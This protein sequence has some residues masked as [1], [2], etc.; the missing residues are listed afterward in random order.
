[1]RKNHFPLQLLGSWNWCGKRCCELLV[2]NEPLAA[3]LIT[4]NHRGWLGS[5]TLGP[6]PAQQAPLLG[7]AGHKSGACCLF[8]RL[9][10]QENQEGPAELCWHGELQGILPRAAPEEESHPHPFLGG[11]LPGFL[12]LVWIS[13]LVP[14]VCVGIWA[15]LWWRAVIPR[16]SFI[17]SGCSMKI[18][19]PEAPQP[20]CIVPAPK[21]L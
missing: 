18:L 19:S 21:F 12:A 1:M 4:A 14:S 2:M 3:P 6:I 20:L 9:T 5:A 11:F 7:S 13:L 10:T 8:D 15:S 17:P 16:G